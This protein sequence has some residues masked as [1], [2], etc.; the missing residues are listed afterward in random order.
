MTS[1][2]RSGNRPPPP[3]GCPG[4]QGVPD[5]ADHPRVE[6]RRPAIERTG[7]GPDVLTRPVAGAPRQADV[8]KAAGQHHERDEAGGHGGAGHV[9]REVPDRPRGE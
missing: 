8:V 1:P 4:R 7:E 9:V 6:V 2:R 3:K 5:R